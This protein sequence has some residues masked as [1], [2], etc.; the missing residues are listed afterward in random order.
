[1]IRTCRRY[2]DE[3]GYSIS[4][5]GFS[6]PFINPEHI[7]DGSLRIEAWNLYCVRKDLRQAHLAAKAGVTPPK[8][9]K[10]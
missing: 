10:P 8:G 6:G 9:K 4:T 3:A 2:L 7:K 1:V 5:Y